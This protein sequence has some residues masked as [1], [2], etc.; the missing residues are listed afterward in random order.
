MAKAA[1]NTTISSSASF[2]LRSQSPAKIGHSPVVPPLSLGKLQLQQIQPV[3]DSSIQRQRGVPLSRDPQNAEKDLPVPARNVV[4]SSSLSSAIPMPTSI[5]ARRLGSPMKK[6]A[7]S[8]QL[9]TMGS[10]PIGHEKIDIKGKVSAISAV[11]NAKL[12]PQASSA[13]RQEG[14][15][16]I[17][18]KRVVLDTEIGLLTLGESIG[19]GAFAQVY[20]A[21]LWS[22]NGSTV[23]VKK[24]SVDKVDKG[25]YQSIQAELT[26]LKRLNHHNIVHVLGQHREGSDHYI[27]MEYMENGSLLSIIKEFGSLPEQ[28]IAAYMDQ[29][30]SALV[31]LHSEGIIHRDIKAA[32]ILLTKDGDVKLA[33]FGVASAIQ[34]GTERLSVIGSPYWMPPEM[35]EM[36]GV[37][38]TSDVWSLGATIIELLTTEPPFFKTNPMS[39]MFQIVQE[40]PVI[41]PEASSELKDFLSLCFKKNPEERP[42][43]LTLRNHPFIVNNN[44]MV[45]F[46]LVVLCFFH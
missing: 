20:K 41:P 27:I 9:S 17:Q 11:F 38:H 15:S 44:I 43:A 18:K 46:V 30:L 19:R 12:A 6:L 45:L 8:D 36:T 35:I 32:N 1:N 42:Q 23:A 26:L 3:G 10:S 33:D 7:S 34:E 25:V 24:F 29:I 21:L 5:A 37:H 39:A 31:Y 22:K 13:P 4:P 2:S 14:I 28:L 40:G 16:D